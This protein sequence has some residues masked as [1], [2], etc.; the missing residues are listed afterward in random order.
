[1]VCYNVLEKSTASVFRV[2]VQVD[3]EVTGRRKSVGHI[4]WFERI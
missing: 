2:Q 3:F 4:G 1:M